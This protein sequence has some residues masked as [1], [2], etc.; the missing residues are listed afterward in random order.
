MQQARAAMLVRRAIMSFSLTDRPATPE[1][2]HGEDPSARGKELAGPD[3]AD[4][5]GSCGHEQE[6]IREPS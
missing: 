6:Q 4:Q 5:D 2:S 3:D 1:F